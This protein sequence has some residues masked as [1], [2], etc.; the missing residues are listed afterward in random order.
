MTDKFNENET[1]K[2]LDKFDEIKE[3]FNKS[4]DKTPEDDMSFL[5]EED[6]EEAGGNVMSKRNNIKL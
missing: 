1:D 4:R 6:Q 5:P 3:M 2:F